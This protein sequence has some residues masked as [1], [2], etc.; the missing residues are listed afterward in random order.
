[1]ADRRPTRGLNP[2]VR[3][4][5]GCPPER[6]QPGD[7]LR[8]LLESGDHEAMEQVTESPGPFRP[9]SPRDQG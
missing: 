2:R 4:R 1:M 7:E 9:R 8:R 3:E 5:V 6:P